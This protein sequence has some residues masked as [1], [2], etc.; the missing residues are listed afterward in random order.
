MITTINPANS[1]KGFYTVDLD[2]MSEN[3]KKTVLGLELKLKEESKTKDFLVRQEA[4]KDSV[5]LSQ[6]FDLRAS[7]KNLQAG[8][9]VYFKSFNMGSYENS[10]KFEASDIQKAYDAKCQQKKDNIFV[11]V[12]AI[13]LTA[14]LGFAVANYTKR[15]QPVKDMIKNKIEMTNDTLKN[16]IK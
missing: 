2:K 13:L 15:V 10:D 7:K 3:Q 11:A 5:S 6:V 16:V 9:Y 14:Y 4:G 8:E 12:A 1:F